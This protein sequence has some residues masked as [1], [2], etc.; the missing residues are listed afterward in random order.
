MTSILQIVYRK[1]GWGLFNQY[2]EKDTSLF[3][4]HNP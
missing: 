3:Y 4:S 2:H 1:V